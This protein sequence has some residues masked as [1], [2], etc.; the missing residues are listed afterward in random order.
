[1]L[2][3]EFSVPVVLVVQGSYG[4]RDFEVYRYKS[5]VRGNGGK[6]ISNL[7]FSSIITFFSGGHH[8][9]STF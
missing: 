7:L 9:M 8:Y 3:V 2:W 4:H 1:M 6:I 5:E